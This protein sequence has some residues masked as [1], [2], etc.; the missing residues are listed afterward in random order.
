[1]AQIF[2]NFNRIHSFNSFGVTLRYFS[3]NPKDTCTRKIFNHFHKNGQASS[4]NLFPSEL[5]RVTTKKDSQI[6]VAEEAAAQQIAEIISQFHTENVPFFELNP[7]PCILSNALIQ[8]LNLKKFGLIEKNE[9]FLDIQ[10]VHFISRPDMK[11]DLNKFRLPFV[12]CRNS[13]KPM[14]QKCRL[15][16]LN[17]YGHIMELLPISFGRNVK[18]GN[19]TKILRIKCLHA[20]KQTTFIV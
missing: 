15:N 11:M 13:R 16:Q 1:M 19:G 12:H 5:K 18:D 8:K 2:Q 10:K 17:Q 14:D 3:V 9:E 6:Y 4:L 7:G 20:F